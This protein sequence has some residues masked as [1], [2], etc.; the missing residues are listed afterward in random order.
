M[1][2]NSGSSGGI[3]LTRVCVRGFVTFGD[4]NEKKGKEIE[5]ELSP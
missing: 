1:L 4:I 3:S 5:A 2:L